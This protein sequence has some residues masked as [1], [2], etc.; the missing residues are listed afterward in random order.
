MSFRTDVGHGDGQHKEENAMPETDLPIKTLSG[1]SITK[2]SKFQVN[3]PH[4]ERLAAGVG[5]RSLALIFS[6][7]SSA[8]RP[9]VRTHREPAAPQN[10]EKNTSVCR[11]N[12]GRSCGCIFGGNV[13]TLRAQRGYLVNKIRQDV[14]SERWKWY[15][16]TASSTER[17]ESFEGCCP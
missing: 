4:L 13:V 2:R 12:I 9:S 7:R 16:R 15:E 10:V 3:A 14:D 6:D 17:F 1:Q 5:A 11:R 8:A